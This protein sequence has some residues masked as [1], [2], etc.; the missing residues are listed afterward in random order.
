MVN[1]D[2]N[3]LRHCLCINVTSIVSRMYATFTYWFRFNK[4]KFSYSLSSSTGAQRTKDA[5]EVLMARQQIVLLCRAFKVQPIDMVYI[6]YK[7]ALS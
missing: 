2:M 1:I 3:I 6:D 4:A 7:G 5:Q